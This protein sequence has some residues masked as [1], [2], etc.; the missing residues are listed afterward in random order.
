MA[1][2]FIIKLFVFLGLLIGVSLALNELYKSF[3]RNNYFSYEKDRQFRNY[4]GKLEYLLMGDSH[5]QNGINPEFLENSFNYAGAWENYVQ[6][7][8]K[9]KNIVEEQKRIPENIILPVDLGSFTSF[10]RERFKNDHY[11]VNYMDYFEVA[12]NFGDRLFINKWI[13]GNYF[14]YAECYESLFKY[15]TRK[16]RENMFPNGFKPCIVRNTESEE[17]EL[18]G[19]RIANLYFKN[20]SY[21]NSDL[22]DYFGKMLEFCEQHKIHVILIKMPVAREYCVQASGYFSKDS[23]YNT[24]GNII[25]KHKDNTTLLDYQELF[26]DNPEY[27]YNHD[28][29]NYNGANEF[30]RILSRRLKEGNTP[31]PDKSGSLPAGRQVPRRGR[32]IDCRMAFQS[33]H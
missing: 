27:M 26:F 8:Y 24:V 19:E 16:K 14:T 11:W 31:S 17:R 7:Y 30:T 28:H 3:L 22:G 4:T 23:L 1:K 12:E 20:Y 10:R 2:S 25:E 18:D 6:T 9:L 13:I 33:R 15:L 5:I 32:I 29:L 21:Y